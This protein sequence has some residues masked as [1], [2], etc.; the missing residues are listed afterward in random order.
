MNIVS[1]FEKHFFTKNDRPAEIFRKDLFILSVNASRNQ[2][3][4]FYSPGYSRLTGKELGI[5]DGIILV[6]DVSVAKQNIH[7]R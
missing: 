6:A 3:L 7:S 4:L 2:V 5:N 1:Y